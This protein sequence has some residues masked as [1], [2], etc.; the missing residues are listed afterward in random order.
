MAALGENHRPPGQHSTALTP[1][2]VTTPFTSVAL[3]GHSGEADVKLAIMLAEAI[4]D[5][6]VLA[7]GATS[8]AAGAGGAIASSVTPLNI[9]FVTDAS[10]APRSSFPSGAL[11]LDCATMRV[12]PG[13]VSAEVGAGEGGAAPRVASSVLNQPSVKPSLRVK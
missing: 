8:A 10:G 2:C 13:A 1:L 12:A 11:L 3:R 9:V 4:D 6:E 5:F 7:V